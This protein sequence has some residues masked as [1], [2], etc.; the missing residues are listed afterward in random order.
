MISQRWK[1]EVLW[2]IR[3]LKRRVVRPRYDSAATA[4]VQDRNGTRRGIH[5]ADRSQSHFVFVSYDGS[6]DFGGPTVNAARLLPELKRRGH[7]VT[8][9]LVTNGE[10]TTHEAGLRTA[11]VEC[12]I[13]PRQGYTESLTR[14]TLNLIEDLQPSVFVPN[15]WIPGCFAARWV[16]EAGV[17][18]IAA[19]RSDDPLYEGIIDQFVL[20]A[21]KWAV[22]GMVCVSKDLEGRVRRHHPHLTRT[23]VIPSGVPIPD[24]AHNHGDGFRIAYVGRFSQQQKRIL[25]VAHAIMMALGEI[26]DARATFFGHGRELEQL[27]AL[28]KEKSIADRIEIAGP[29]NPGSIQK[30]LLAFDVIVLLSDYEGTP[31]ALM[32]AMACGVVPVS[33]DIPG[34]VRELVIDNKTGLLVKDRDRSFVDAIKTLHGN[35]DRRAE[36]GRNAREHI[37]ALFSLDHAADLWE[38]FCGRLLSEAGPRRPMYLPTRLRLPDLAPTL[39]P[40]MS[41]K[42]SFAK[43]LFGAVIRV[44]ARSTRTSIHT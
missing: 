13:L 9:L 29:V 15:I 28:V 25:D 31:G 3:R 14:S 30:R 24:R 6:N 26:S 34:G 21:P 19:Y 17:P 35:V 4:R 16:R 43:R 38:E 18:T 8:A 36:I 5:G 33:L 10:E 20:G 23:V 2:A 22:S 44:L 1:A 27:K 32:D 42:P 41:S 7:R 39:V 37:V 12:R 40:H 11:G